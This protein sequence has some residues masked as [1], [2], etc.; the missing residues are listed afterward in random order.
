[1]VNFSDVPSNL[2]AARPREVSRKGFIDW[3]IRYAITPLRRPSFS[4]M[5]ARFSS[6]GYQVW[7]VNDFDDRFVV[8]PPGVT[9]KGLKV[10]GDH[11]R[12]TVEG[13]PAGGA[14]LLVRAAF[15]PRWRARQNGNKLAV[16]AKQPRPETFER[17]EQI[18]IRA[19][20]GEVQLSCTGLMPR[21]WRGLFLSLVG[22]AIAVAGASLGRRKRIEW[23]VAKTW[24]R[25]RRS[26]R[27]AGASIRA[28]AGG[29]RWLLLPAVLVLV[30]AIGAISTLRGR[31]QLFMPAMGGAGLEVSLKRANGRY[32]P[33]W[34]NL[35]EGGYVCTYLA[36]SPALHVGGWMGLNP[37]LDNTL[38]IARHWAAIRVYLPTAGTARL[39]F[40]R[41][42]L[43]GGALDLRLISGGSAEMRVLF[44][45][46]PA[47]KFPLAAFMQKH[48]PVPAGLGSVADVTLEI[49]SEGSV[50]VT[51]EGGASPRR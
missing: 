22:L 1:V 25:M 40:S 39:K 11:I 6:G 10:D 47:D 7:E 3:N 35:A 44:D 36:G 8:A 46:T 15:Y 42:R 33:C 19:F 5:T 38:E 26:L 18:A 43:N 48:I 34:P 9:I 17:Q 24:R 16:W 27:E 50:T 21:F 45:K 20:N 49:Q 13:A 31:R 37:R 30:L 14:E 28:R 29:R 41:V 12:F 51:F 32:V 23:W 2:L 4:E